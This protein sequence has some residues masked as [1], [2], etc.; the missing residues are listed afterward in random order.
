MY[1]LA[2]PR[3]ED[4]MPAVEHRRFPVWYSAFEHRALTSLE[5]EENALVVRARGR[6]PRRIGREP[7]VE[8]RGRRRGTYR[9]R[10]LRY[11]REIV[12]ASV[13]QIF[14]AVASR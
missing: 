5:R 12:L 11:L 6:P 7:R 3:D 10:G 8:V 9:Q 2:L 1:G 4:V 13:G 14:D